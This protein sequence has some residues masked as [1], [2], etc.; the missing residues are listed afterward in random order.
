[1]AYIL[2]DSELN[3]SLFSKVCSFCKHFHYLPTRTCS[4]FPDGIPE[5]IWSGEK[6]HRQPYPGDYGT[7][8]EADEESE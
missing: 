5:I 8:F 7:R 2:G 4:A 1:M 3:R 6:D